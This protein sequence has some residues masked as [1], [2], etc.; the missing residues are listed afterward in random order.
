VPGASPSASGITESRGI[1]PVDPTR[2]LIVDD[3]SETL[4]SP[5][6]F[7]V[8]HAFGAAAVSTGADAL[9]R[10]RQERFDV[11]LADLNIVDPGDGFAVVGAMRQAAV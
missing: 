1:L 3:D 8:D 9:E 5:Q 10:I 7:V 6:G 2:I 4:K 11:L